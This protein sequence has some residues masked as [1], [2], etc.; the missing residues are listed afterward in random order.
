MHQIIDLY[1]MPNI[2]KCVQQIWS[3]N[4]GSRITHSWE[5]VGANDL[6]HGNPCFPM[7]RSNL[8][9]QS[10][11]EDLLNTYNNLYYAIK[12]CE[13][14]WIPIDMNNSCDFNNIV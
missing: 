11:P 7:Q 6:Y 9:Q 10:P 3:S 12:I 13:S 8:V 4:D 5:G 2:S 1:I 14:M